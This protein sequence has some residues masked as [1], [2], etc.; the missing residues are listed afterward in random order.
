MVLLLD[1]A[2][3]ASESGGD[4]IGGIVAVLMTEYDA[5]YYLRPRGAVLNIPGRKNPGSCLTVLPHKVK[6]CT[7]KREIKTRCAYCHGR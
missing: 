2:T 5:A 7:K 1:Y 3:D 4:R 6:R